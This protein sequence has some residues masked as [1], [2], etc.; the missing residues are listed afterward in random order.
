MVKLFDVLI[1]NSSFFPVEIK[2]F[3]A[4][5]EYVSDDVNTR[6]SCFHRNGLLILKKVFFMSE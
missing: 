4:F 3:Y 5:A 1:P 2:I 6:L